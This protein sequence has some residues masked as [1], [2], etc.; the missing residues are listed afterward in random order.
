MPPYQT[1]SLCLLQPPSGSFSATNTLV[2]RRSC[3]QTCL[4]NLRWNLA[5][6]FLFVVVFLEISW[7]KT[8]FYG[9]YGFMDFCVKRKQSTNPR[10]C[11]HVWGSYH[12]GGVPAESDWHSSHN[13]HALA[14]VFHV[15]VRWKIHQ[16]YNMETYT[17][18][19][20]SLC[21]WQQKALLPL[22]EKIK[23][24]ETNS[25]RAPEID[26][27]SVCFGHHAR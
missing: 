10:S 18:I 25:W 26:W 23:G 14:I 4:D 16:V 15:Q 22:S 6:F 2:K 13:L 27:D 5:S 17:M 8:C 19:H 11:C 7:G 1:I 21:K 12:T 9:S 24:I 20:H 3:L